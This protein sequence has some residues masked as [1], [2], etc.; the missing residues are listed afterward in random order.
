MTP[1]QEHDMTDRATELRAA[2]A[3]ERIWAGTYD[4]CQSD[5]ADEW[6]MSIPYWR[7]DARD[8]MFPTEYVRSDIHAA[9]LDLL[10]KKD[11]EL[12]RDG[13]FYIDCEFDGHDGPLLS[14]AMVREDGW[15]THIEVAEVAVADPWVLANVVPILG[16]H[17][18][19]LSCR[20][21][22]REVGRQ[23]RQF[24]GDCQRP[25]IIADSPV[26]IGRFCRAISTG[27][28][29]GW[30]SIGYPQMIFIVSNVD[31]YPTKLKG[32]VQ[33][34]AWWDAMALR[35]ALTPAPHAGNGEGGAG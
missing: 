6:G 11:E 35:A 8:P 16:S 12:A 18:A 23:L 19:D 9:A 32:A 2:D 14:I 29:G 17:K 1:T 25:K 21:R 34:N 31:C 26:D 30:A 24:I 13:T 10:A 15:S 22:P 3:P 27:Y 28:D 20:V 5:N 7:A 4:D 33:H